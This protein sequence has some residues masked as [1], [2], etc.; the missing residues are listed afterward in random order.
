MPDR[1]GSNSVTEA[2]KREY[3][4]IKKSK[5]TLKRNRIIAELDAACRKRV[6]ED[7][8]NNTC[9][10]CGAFA[11]QWD[12]ERG[13][14]VKIQW[15]HIYTREYHCVR[16]DDDNSMA[17]CDRCHLWFTHHHTQ[18]VRWFSE[19][20]PCRW[21]KISHIVN[22]GVKVRPADLLAELRDEE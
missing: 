3:M 11:G 9:Q 1:R 15:S 18:G 12:S 2:G 10:K 4:A 13:R 17:K 19:K 8:D 22:S 14:F 6:V 21:D 7:R 20:F 5:A 16:W